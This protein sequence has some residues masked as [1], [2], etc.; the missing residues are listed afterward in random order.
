MV[1]IPSP[2]PNGCKLVAGDPRTW[3]ECLVK[4]TGYPPAYKYVVDI[5]TGQD[6]PWLVLEGRWIIT[7][8]TAAA[9]DC[10]WRDL[11]EEQ[12]PPLTQLIMWKFASTPLQNR[13]WELTIHGSGAACPSAQTIIVP[14]GSDC[15][16]DLLFP[17][18]NTWT[19]F[20]CPS[21][22]TDPAD[23]NVWPVPWDFTKADL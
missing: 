7:R 5:P 10:Q 1:A 3:C 18:S 11:A 12:L 16:E 14:A 19:Y 21:P 20:G 6:P 17:Q 8:F 22:G 15:C 13:F 9:V 23:V 4:C 2:Y